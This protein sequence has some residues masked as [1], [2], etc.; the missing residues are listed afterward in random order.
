MNSEPSPPSAGASAWVV[1]TQ[2]KSHRIVYFTDDPE[3]QPPMQGD[4]YYVSP[5]HGELPS[6]M[7]LRNCWRWRFNGMEFVDAGRTPPADRQASLLRNNR[8]ALLDLLNQRID[9]I[10]RPFEPSSL[11]GVELRARKL[12]EARAVLRGERAE[13]SLLHEVAAAH[14]CTLDEMAHRIVDSDRRR[15]EMLLNTER[16]REGLAAAIGRATS[17]Q[18]LVVLRR[19][20]TDEIAADRVEPLAHK[21]EHTTPEQ[22]KQSPDPRQLADERLRLRVQLRNRINDLRRPY[23]S[24]YVLDEHVFS[25]K[26]EVAAVVQRAGGALPAA[27]DGSLLVSHAAARG[28]A[29]AEAAREVLAESMELRE[30]LVVTEQ[31]KDATLSRIAAAS[32]LADVRDIGHAIAGLVVDTRAPSGE[33]NQKRP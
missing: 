7:T 17:Q 18:Q 1:V 12:A 13:V 29:L 19:R 10:R 31:M 8:E 27:V 25:R 2:V 24:Q 9:A 4:W 5:Y 14:L 32:T 30:V 33:P 3:Y 6:G 20:V 23:V 15:S 21:A 11:G 26:A 28:Q 16:Q 22:L